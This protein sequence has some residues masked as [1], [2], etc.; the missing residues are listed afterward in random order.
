[1]ELMT[2]ALPCLFWTICL[3]GIQPVGPQGPWVGLEEVQ[4][5]LKATRSRPSSALEWQQ[6]FSTRVRLFLFQARRLPPEVQ[7]EKA[8]LSDALRIGTWNCLTLDVGPETALGDAGTL[9]YSDWQFHNKAFDL[10]TLQE[11]RTRLKG[12]VGL[13]HYHALCTPSQRGEG[14]LITLVHRSSGFSVVSFDAISHRLSVAHLAA[15]STM[16]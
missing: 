11:S 2:Q 12:Q 15:G 8:L 16:V 7:D 5:Q 3:A 10:V 9:R 4:C 6:S 14:G 13:T 1:M